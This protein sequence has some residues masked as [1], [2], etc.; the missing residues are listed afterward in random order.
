MTVN[1]KETFVWRCAPWIATV[2]KVIT[3]ALRYACFEIMDFLLRWFKDKIWKSTFC[4]LQNI[5]GYKDFE[6]LLSQKSQLSMSFPDGSVRSDE[7]FQ[8]KRQV[9][10]TLKFSEN[11]SGQYDLI[12]IRK[13]YPYVPISTCPFQLPTMPNVKFREIALTHD[14][15]THYGVTFTAESCNTLS[16]RFLDTSS[17]LS[18]KDRQMNL[19]FRRAKQIQLLLFSH[20]PTTLLAK[21]ISEMKEYNNISYFLKQ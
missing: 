10:Y 13:N 8:L 11:I 5:L 6:T 3:T 20:G 18:Q 1:S 21:V 15:V 9:M 4:F 16:I 7:T 17:M 12:V 14:N 2:P 19:A